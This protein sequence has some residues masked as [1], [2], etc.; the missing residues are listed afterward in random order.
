[1]YSANPPVNG[2]FVHSVYYE[3][4]FEYT[5]NYIGYLAIFILNWVVTFDAGSC[6]FV[7]DLYISLIIFHTWGH[8]KIL[9]YNLRHFPQPSL[10]G[11]FN[12]IAKP[13]CYDEEESKKITAMLKEQ[14]NYHRIITK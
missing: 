8:I 4:P 14:I 13:V 5:T 3:L 6:F 12:G 1:M 10:E 2:T 7:F 11:K 9:D